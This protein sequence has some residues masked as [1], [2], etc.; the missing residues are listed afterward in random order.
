MLLDTSGLYS[1][2]DAADVRHAEAVKLLNAA[3]LR[4]THS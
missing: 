3:S 2:L 4:L 1:Y